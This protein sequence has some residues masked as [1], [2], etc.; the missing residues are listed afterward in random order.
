MIDFRK[1][2]TGNHIHT[3]ETPYTDGKSY[4]YCLVSMVINYQL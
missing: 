4:I 1:Q 3:I 2:N